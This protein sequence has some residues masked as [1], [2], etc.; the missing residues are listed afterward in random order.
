MPDGAK[1]KGGTDKGRETKLQGEQGHKQK[2][3]EQAE[4][5]KS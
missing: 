1:T 2:E 5:R 4:L 3:E